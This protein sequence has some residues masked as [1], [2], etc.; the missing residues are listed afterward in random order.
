VINY[1]TSPGFLFAILKRAARL[2]LLSFVEIESIPSASGFL[3]LN[4]SQSY[5]KARQVGQ[6]AAPGFTT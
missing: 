6:K 3:N 1:Y 4:L 5:F 2:F